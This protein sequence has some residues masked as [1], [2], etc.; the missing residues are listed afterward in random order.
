MMAQQTIQ[1]SIAQNIAN[2]NTTGYKQDVP[3]FKALHGMMLQRGTNAGGTGPQIG[4]LGT[5]V[6]NDQVYTDWQAGAIT[7]TGNPLDASLERGPNADTSYFF[8][9]RSAQGERYTRA[10]N[11]RLDGAGN[12]LT[13]S[14]LAVLDKAG[15]PIVARGNGSLKLDRYGNLRFAN[16]PATDPPI[17]QLKIVQANPAQMQKD[18]DTLFA[19]T[20]PNA[21]RPTALPVV[22]P[23]SLEQSNVNSVQSL[24]Q[25]ITVTRSFDMAQRAISTQDDLLRHA[26]NDLGKL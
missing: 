10:G 19:P 7:Q 22:N 1:E 4:E 21:A 26:S 6:A 3:T 24:V 20:A 9:V 18:G 25:M 14:G 12:L 17:A 8:A 13:Q 23:G 5:G 2:A 15:A 11:F 16:R